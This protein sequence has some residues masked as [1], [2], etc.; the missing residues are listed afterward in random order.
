MSKQAFKN[1]RRLLNLPVN[2]SPLPVY[3]FPLGRAFIYKFVDGQPVCGKCVNE[4]IDKING[5]AEHPEVWILSGYSLHDGTDPV[6]CE[7][8]NQSIENKP[9]VKQES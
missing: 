1:V 9:P 4:S 3:S 6:F 7:L 2:R 5:Q 8:C